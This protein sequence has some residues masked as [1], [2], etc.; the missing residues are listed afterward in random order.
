MDAKYHG[1]FDKMG[2]RR[3]EQRD[4]R[5]VSEAVGKE[6]VYKQVGKA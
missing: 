4:G 6:S 3:E 2:G 1:S 5:P